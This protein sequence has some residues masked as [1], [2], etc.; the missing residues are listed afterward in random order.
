MTSAKLY[1][2][3]A[4]AVLRKHTCYGAAGIEREQRQI[5]PVKLADSGLGDTEAY[6]GDG[7]KGFGSGSGVID[8]HVLPLPT[9]RAQRHRDH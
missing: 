3:S 7:V 1:W 5:A 9:Q 4:K 8:G 2:R 6:A